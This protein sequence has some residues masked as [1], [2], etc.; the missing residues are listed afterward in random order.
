MILGTVYQLEAGIVFHLSYSIPRAMIT[1]TMSPTS[2]RWT[3][4]SRDHPEVVGEGGDVVE[5]EITLPPSALPRWWHVR[6]RSMSRA[7]RWESKW[8]ATSVCAASTRSS[9]WPW[10]TSW[11]LK[12]MSTSCGWTKSWRH[13]ETTSAVR[14]TRLARSTRAYWR[15]RWKGETVFI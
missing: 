5:A 13:R 6:S 10:R 7:L 14:V 8:L 2:P 15:K 12:W 1:S 3:R 4:S 11:R 9:W